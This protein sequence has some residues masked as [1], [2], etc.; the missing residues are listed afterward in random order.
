VIGSEDEGEGGGQGT[1][2]PAIE[3]LLQSK[4]VK[5]RAEPREVSETG[6]ESRHFGV[7]LDGEKSLPDAPAHAQGIP[8]EVADSKAGD[9]R[10]DEADP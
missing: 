2:F 1:Q 9:G 5:S 6:A 3:R 7:L 4:E 8:P 10:D